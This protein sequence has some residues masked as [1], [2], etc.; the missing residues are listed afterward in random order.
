MTENLHKVC[1]EISGKSDA[2]KRLTLHQL[3]LSIA[4]MVISCCL[5]VAICRAAHV[6]HSTHGFVESFYSAPSSWLVAQRL[7]VPFFHGSIPR[8]FFRD[9]FSRAGFVPG[10][11]DRF[12]ARPRHPVTANHHLGEAVVVGRNKIRFQMKMSKLECYSFWQTSYS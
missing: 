7:R 5:A 12:K 11:A 8:P 10:Q 1:L 4:Q 3:Q 6:H 2:L 9:P